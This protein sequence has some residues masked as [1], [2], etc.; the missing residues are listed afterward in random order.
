MAA[1]SRA[2]VAARRGPGICIGILPCGD[3]DPSTPR[4]GYPNEF[5]DL[6]IHT[7]LPHSGDL[8][9]DPLSRNHINVLSCAA[10]VALPGGAGTRSEVMLAVR[11]RK[12]AIAYGSAGFADIPDTVARATNIEDIRRFLERQL[13]I[14]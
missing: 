7:H 3:G 9:T 12:P 2:F 1:V 11:Y 6:A 4:D 10:L 8:G 5:V 13:R 14:Q